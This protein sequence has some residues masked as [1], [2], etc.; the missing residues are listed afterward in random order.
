M[1][2]MELKLA[3]TV[4]YRSTFDEKTGTIVRVVEEGNERYSYPRFSHEVD[5][6]LRKKYSHRCHGGAFSPV[7]ETVDVSI[8]D[9]C[10]FGCPYC[11]QDSKP[12]LA[13]APKELVE[14]ILKGFDQPPYQ[15]AIG[16]GEP[17]LHPDFPYIL[18]KCRELGTVP[19]YTTAGD[20][21]SG[22]II[23]ATNEVCGGV[24]MTFHAFKGIDW[25]VAHYLKLKGQLDDRVQL[26]VHLIADKDVA[27]NLYTLLDR[28]K[29][30]G[31]LNLVLLAYYPDVGRAT[32]DSLLTK[33]VYTKDFPE[34]LAATRSANY[35]IAFSEGL[36]PYFL[37]RPKLGINTDF[38]MPSEGHFSCYFDPKGRISTSSFQPPR[39]ENADT[40]YTKTSQALWDAVWPRNE[41]YGDACGSCSQRGQCSVP[42]TFHYLV[43]AFA[44]HNSVPL[45]EVPA[46]P[47]TAY[48]H[49]LDDED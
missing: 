2:S 27:K 11:Y 12:D 44:P 31:P 43:C 34:A 32:M 14:T 29:D 37:S 15:M 23:K 33:R 9:K 10:H 20:K 42:D 39:G 48:E 35:K 8:T 38:A 45:T 30:L 1:R 28:H 17:T 5:E 16:G 21:I 47:K 3:G 13:H 22:R 24:A 41:P 18:H 36:L 26:N 46:K 7:P 19:N 4:L 25:F 40:A 49:L 6:A